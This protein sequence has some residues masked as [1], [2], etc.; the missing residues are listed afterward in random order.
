M[1][2]NGKHNG[3]NGHSTVGVRGKLRLDPVTVQLI[4]SARR[5]A[6]VPAVAE[7]F[8]VSTTTVHRACRKARQM[9]GA[10]HG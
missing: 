3:T 9:E 5:L 6:T 4:A 1:S 2:A 10:A 7:A 8:R